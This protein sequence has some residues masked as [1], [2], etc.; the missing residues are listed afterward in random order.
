MICVFSPHRLRTTNFV[1]LVLLIVLMSGSLTGC[2]HDTQSAENSVSNSVPA[3]ASTSGTK[4]QESI[5]IDE[6]K[7]LFVDVAGRAGI[8]FKHDSGGTGD[9]FYV[10]STPPG[11]AFI[12]FDN[13]D[14]LDIFLV[15]SGPTGDKPG[16]P[17]PFCRLYRNQGE[18]TFVDVTKGSGI[19]RDF[20]YGQGV[21]VAD[22]DNDGYDDLFITSYG[23]NHLLRNESGSGRWQDVTKAQGLG[24]SFGYATSAAWGD[25]DND[26]RLDLYVCYYSQWS[27]QTDREC[28]TPDGKRDYCSP[29][30]YD[31]EPHRLYHNTAR[32]F[33]DVT[34]RVGINAK[35]G[36]GLAVAWV[37]ANDDGRMDVFVA[38]DLTPN[39]LWRNNGDGTFTDIAVEAGVAFGENGQAMAGMGVAIAD[40]DRSGR[41]SLYVTNFSERP[42]ILF[43]RVAPGVFE[44]VTASAGLGLSHLKFLSFGCEFFDYD[45]DGWKDLIINN[46]HVQMLPGQRRQ[47]VTYEQAKQ[48]LRNTGKGFEEVT[49]TALLGDLV[50]P[51]IG[52]GLA[53]GDYDNDGRVDALA[54]NKDAPTQLFRNQKA[55]DNHWV[56]FKTLG[57]K[58]NRDGLHAQFIL[59]AGGA[60]QTATVRAGS[61]YLSSSDRRVYFG[62]GKAE[63]V[64]S[65]TI[66]WPSGKR[67]T[68]RDLPANVFYTLTEGRGITARHAA[69]TTKK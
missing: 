68:L 30:L 53:V 19:D 38:N 40:Y 57:T 66:R 47:D 25:Y 3:P 36:R 32:G 35:K 9:F 28:K 49:D 63:R 23:A 56:S 45:A 13:D 52:R 58:S 65:I 54:S 34:Q 31:A 11:C 15:Q 8:D 6:S 41:E 39:F 7:A 55:N 43:H 42:N 20:G 48:L 61:S 64:T 51:R 69:S 12:D 14:D 17:R 50:R 10:E 5:E 60:R 29:L 2:R 26:G 1:G 24:K 4:N 22:Y 16:A 44:D 21:A 33:I 67:E 46:G 18:G 27:W 37:D 59:E 62:L